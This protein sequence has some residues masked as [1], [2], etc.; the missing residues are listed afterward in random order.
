MRCCCCVVCSFIEKFGKGGG[1]PHWHGNIVFGLRHSQRPGATAQQLRKQPAQLG[2]LMVSSVKHGVR[3]LNKVEQNLVILL[4]D[5]LMMS[6][7]DY[8]SY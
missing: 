7:L 5:D 6:C 3:V 1:E 2:R 8:S 4:I